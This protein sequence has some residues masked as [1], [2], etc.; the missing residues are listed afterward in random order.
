M[1]QPLL[2]A[3][4]M[5]LEIFINKFICRNFSIADR[6]SIRSSFFQNLLNTLIKY[7]HTI[8][9]KKEKINIF[10]DYVNEEIKEN[11]KNGFEY[12]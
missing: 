1:G 11:Y 7:K 12:F 9:I 2:K 3:I 4:E 6:E 10:L 5:L 8:K